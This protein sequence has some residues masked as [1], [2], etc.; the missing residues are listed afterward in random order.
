MEA[1]GTG[2]DKTRFTVVLSVSASG[3]IGKTMVILKG[4]KNPPKCRIPKNMVVVTSKGGSMNETLMLRWVRECYPSVSLCSPLFSNRRSLLLMDAH[5]SHWHESV[6][7]NMRKMKADS[8]CIPAR[9]TSFLQPLDV[10]LNAPFKVRLRQKW[11][12]W[13]SNGVKEY[14]PKGMRR[15][16]SWA[17]VFQWV[18]DAVKSLMPEM[19]VKAFVCCGIKARGEE[20]HVTQFG[21][22]LRALLAPA[23]ESDAQAMLVGPVD[24]EAEENDDEDMLNM[25]ERAQGDEESEISELSD[26]DD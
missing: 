14:T 2:H 18:D 1:V 20:V 9:M 25:V 3:K 7:E 15:R 22:R 23:T 24:D 6:R 13:M 26:D 10:G 11:E 12:D 19:I 4:R 17:A 5:G 8:L 21:S 16:P